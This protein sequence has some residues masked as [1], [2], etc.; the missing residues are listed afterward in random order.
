[1]VSVDDAGHVTAI[2][3]VGS[4]QITAAVGDVRSR[5]VLVVVAQPARGY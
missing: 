4:A 2:G 1:M 3:A 5:P